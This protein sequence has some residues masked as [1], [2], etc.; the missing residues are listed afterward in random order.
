MGLPGCAADTAF[1]SWACLAGL[2][3][4]RRQRH[5]MVAFALLL[6]VW[7]TC[8]LGPVALMRYMLGF[9]YAMPLLLAAMLAPGKHPVPLADRPLQSQ[10]GLS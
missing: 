7:V 2:A 1:T 4:Y 10:G 6:G 3:H 9:F 5:W 8:L